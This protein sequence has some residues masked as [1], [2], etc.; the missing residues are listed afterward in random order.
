MIVII[1]KIFSE[2]PTECD[3]RKYLG[4]KKKK[5]VTMVKYKNE[6]VLGSAET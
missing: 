2:T 4:K 6:K 1:R 5:L 3:T